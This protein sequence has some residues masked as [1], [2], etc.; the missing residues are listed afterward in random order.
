MLK[1]DKIP[2]FAIF[3]NL[4]ITKRECLRQVLAVQFFNLDSDHIEK[5]VSETFPLRENVR[6]TSFTYY[7]T[8][9]TFFE[10]QWVSFLVNVKGNYIFSGQPLAAVKTQSDRQNIQLFELIKYEYKLRSTSL[11]ILKISKFVTS[12]KTSFVF[13]NNQILPPMGFGL[14]VRGLVAQG[15]TQQSIIRGG[16]TLRFFPL[17]PFAVYLL[18][19]ERFLNLFTALKCTCQLQ[20]ET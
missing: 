2:A 14:K 6:Y 5:Y 18:K 1:V 20:T 13:Q 11:Y 12:E 8:H 15:G 9:S 16:P 19:P 17:T 10:K 4:E 3:F 7:F